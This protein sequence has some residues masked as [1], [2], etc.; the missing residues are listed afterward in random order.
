MV[1]KGQQ[2]VKAC[3]LVRCAR[4]HGN[5]SMPLAG[6]NE[7]GSLREVLFMNKGNEAGAR[8]SGGAYEENKTA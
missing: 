8:E 5:G 1:T 3:V 4:A 6:G 7:N 2:L